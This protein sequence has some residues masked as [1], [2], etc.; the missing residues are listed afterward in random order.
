MHVKH[1]TVAC[2]AKKTHLG[3]IHLFHISTVSTLLYLLLRQH[4]SYNAAFSRNQL[5]NFSF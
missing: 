1:L 4:L 2:D 5:S 3:V